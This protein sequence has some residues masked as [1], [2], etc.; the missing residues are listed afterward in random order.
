M[1][2][3]S[4]FKITSKELQIGSHSKPMILSL[5]RN[6]NRNYTEEHEKN[7]LNGNVNKRV[8]LCFTIHFRILIHVQNLRCMDINNFT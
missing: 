2:A 7:W 4:R 3:E 5:C 1:N 6:H 8:T